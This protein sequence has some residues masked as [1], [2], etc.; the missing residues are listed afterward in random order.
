MNLELETL[1]M[2]D[3]RLFHLYERN[4]CSVAV[5]YCILLKV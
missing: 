4:T 1:P 3:N 5:N 2:N